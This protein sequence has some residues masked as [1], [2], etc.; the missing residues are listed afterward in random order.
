[1]QHLEQRN[2][3]HYYLF[4]IPGILYFTILVVIPFFA[5]TV[6]SFT[7]WSGVGT[8]KFIGTIMETFDVLCGQNEEGR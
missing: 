5:N 2:Q 3:R 1:M 7:S 4:L 6:L 8:P